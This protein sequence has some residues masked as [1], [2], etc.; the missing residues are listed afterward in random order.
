MSV[1]VGGEWGR[2]GRACH[3]WLAEAATLAAGCAA[4]LA[5]PLAWLRSQLGRASRGVLP[6]WRRARLPYR[7]PQ[8][9]FPPRGDL[10]PGTPARP[11]PSQRQQR[12]R[13]AALRG[14]GG[15]AAAAAAGAAAAALAARTAPARCAAGPGQLAR[16]G[17]QANPMQSYIKPHPAPCILNPPA[18]TP[19]PTHTRPEAPP[20]MRCLKEEKLTILSAMRSQEG[21]WQVAEA[22]TLS[23][24]TCRGRARRQQTTLR[25]PQQC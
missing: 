1:G 4:G 14:R 25:S 22:A 16:P 11:P 6:S 23:S 24:C 3:P 10:R 5:R 13:A 18:P 12:R 2:C 7:A 21:L 20:A 15:R 9:S 19:T 17:R 8:R